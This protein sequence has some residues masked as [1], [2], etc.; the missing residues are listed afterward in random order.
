MS[1]R[2][3]AFD[4]QAHLA[5]FRNKRINAIRIQ[6]VTRGMIAR[7]LPLRKF[8]L[9]RCVI[10]GAVHVASEWAFSAG[11]TWLQS[12]HFSLLSLVSPHLSLPILDAS[13][14]TH[15]SSGRRG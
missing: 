12:S 14:R 2:T 1:R 10:N 5:S 4:M 6:A 8:Q 13:P 3:A 11:S 7:R 15:A 9:L